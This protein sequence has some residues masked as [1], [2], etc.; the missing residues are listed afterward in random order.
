MQQHLLRV[1]LII[2]LPLLLPPP[3][4]LLLLLLPRLFQCSESGSI[5]QPGFDASK[6]F[7][8][9]VITRIAAISSKAAQA[10]STTVQCSAVK[11]S[12]VCLC[13]EAQ[14]YRTSTAQDS[15]CDTLLLTA[16]STAAV[17]S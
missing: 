16:R 15:S 7:I 10:I 17:H 2:L 12:K 6:I 5:E 11:A 13:S 3:P 9:E 14:S 4:L 8:R 1:P